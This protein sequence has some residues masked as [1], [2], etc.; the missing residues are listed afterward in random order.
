MKKYLL[1]I[2]FVSAFFGCS[3]SSSNASDSPESSSSLPT[4]SEKYEISDDASWVASLSDKSYLKQE[5]CDRATIYLSKYFDYAYC[6]SVNYNESK[7]RFDVTVFIDDHEVEMWAPV[8]ACDYW[9]DSDYYTSIVGIGS[10]GQWS[11][12]S[13]LCKITNG[14][15]YYQEAPENIKVKV[16]KPS[17]SASA[18]SSSSLDNYGSSSSMLFPPLSSTS[19]SSVSSS[20]TKQSSSSVKSDCPAF[21]ADVSAY[22]VAYEFADSVNLGKDYTGNV[23]AE[24]GEGNPRGDCESLILDGSSGLKVRAVD[25]FA[26]NAFTIETRIYPTAFASMQNIIASEP[27]GGNRDGWILRLENG[28]LTFLIRDSDKSS[29]WTTVKLEEQLPLNE[30]TTIKVKRLASGSINVSV[31]GFLR[32]AASFVGSVTEPEHGYLGIGY[33][34]ANQGNHERYFEGKIDYIR[35]INADEDSKEYSFTY[36]GLN[37]AYKNQVINVP[38]KS[39]CLSSSCKEDFEKFDFENGTVTTSGEGFKGKAVVLDGSDY[40]AMPWFMDRDVQSGSLDFYYKQ[41]AE[42]LT[43]NLSTALVGNNGA[44]LLTFIAA[45]K[46][47]FY[48]NFDDEYNSASVVLTDVLNWKADGW[49]R[50]TAEWDGETGIMALFINGTQVATRSTSHAKYQASTRIGYDN[51]VFVGYKDECCVGSTLSNAI[52]GYGSIDEIEIKPSLIFDID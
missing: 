25:D 40:I 36:T 6:S 5:I 20:S 35:F 43:G 51:A 47:Y 29:N 27:S 50:I 3:D 46:L 15:P 52:M 18:K 7:K 13:C 34:A 26:A 16:E 32:I 49:N 24:L 39:N 23:D 38:V 44:R 48:K 45:G 14:V 41:P 42:S 2:A 22:T 12:S 10:M 11:A 1:P 28:I 9:L 30:W 17:S 4:C 19:S 37:A 33:D 21:N 31:D 8:H